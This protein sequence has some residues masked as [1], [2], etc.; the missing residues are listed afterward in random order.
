MYCI[1]CGAS[2]PEGVK[3]CPNCGNS[4]STKPGQE[5]SL[6]GKVNPSSNGQPQYEYCEIVFESKMGLVFIK[7]RFWAKAAGPRG[8][9]PAA[10]GKK[11]ETGAPQDVGNRRKYESACDDMV[12][13]L[14]KD[15]WE[16]IPNK[17]PNYWNF[18]FRRLVAI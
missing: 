13:M 3:Y 9:Y 12:M 7:G 5:G 4:Q 6:V 17:G 8:V 2:M 16:L 10:V 1:H 11:W 15:G 14:I 18:K